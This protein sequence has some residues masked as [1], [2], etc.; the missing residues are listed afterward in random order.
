MIQ[1][2]FS[3]NTA[4]FKNVCLFFHKATLALITYENINSSLKPETRFYM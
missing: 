1:E 2:V 4:L 3:C